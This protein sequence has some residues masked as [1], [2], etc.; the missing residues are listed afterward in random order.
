MKYNFKDRFKNYALIQRI[1][2]FI[3]T[4]LVVFLFFPNE[5]MIRYE[6][7]LNQPWK[8]DKLFAPFDFGIHKS[9]EEITQA[10]EEITSNQAPVFS[11]DQA[12]N[13]QML[14]RIDD[15]WELSVDS[16]YACDSI[17]KSSTEL[18]GEWLSTG[19]IQRGEQTRNL[20][21]FDPIFID[22]GG[23]L[24]S[25]SYGD[26]LNINMVF[27][28]MA[29]MVEIEA[30]SHCAPIVMRII[31]ENLVSNAAY[32]DSL[33]E[34]L[35]E[36]GYADIIEIEGK[37]NKGQSIIDRGEIVNNERY[38]VLASL[39]KEFAERTMSVTGFQWSLIGQMA[40]VTI[41]LGLLA[42]FIY[43]NQTR[44]FND[45]R[46]IT[47]SLS[48]VTLGFA[49][50]AIAYSS[51]AVSMY[52]IPIGI[53]PLLLRMF[54]DFRV[55]IFSFLI[56]ILMVALFSSNPLEYIL[57]QMSAISFATLYQSSSVKRSRM[58]GTAM[59]VFLGYS[60]IYMA[61]SVA[62][63]GSMN[64]IITANF[65]WF[66][67]NGLLC[68]MVFPLIY[69]VE[70]V[71]GYTSETTLLELSDS[72]Q[73]LLKE[74]AVKAPGTFQH[75]MQVAN[76]A[77]KISS[78]IGGNS[79][80]LRT[81]AM[82][83]DIGK[84]N[85]PQFFI[86]NQLPDNNPHDDLEPQESAQIII[87]HVRQGIEKALQ[88]NIPIDIIQFIQTHHGT[89]KARYFYKRALD[90]NPDADEATFTYPGPRPSTKEQAI[91]MMADSVEAASRSLKKYD[92]E[93]LERLV[94]MIID[95]QKD[96]GQFTEAPITFKDITIAKSVLKTALKG[97][98]HQRISYD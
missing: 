12:F 34:L 62:Q 50:S 27:D 76:L 18:I 51:N 37:V 69:V 52:I 26:A 36:N 94:D 84:M 72:N 48:L 66:A 67:I 39:E 47:L 56:L 29:G 43:M 21:R 93:S 78:K 31:T 86:E 81:A 24:T 96:D 16:N 53:A 38:K 4:L 2:A 42:L 98:F 33:T 6:Y 11:I 65:G 60:V 71:F 44:L 25:I 20:S 92:H 73:P 49:M 88:F 13:E 10:K 3:L 59:L 5:G 63:N 97:I 57:V 68:M 90:A 23:N 91:L 70:K 85:E 19:I 54:F 55:S 61:I 1:V 9:A 87:G 7:Q 17:R 79:V 95:G 89:S 32:N 46:P 15:A 58:L 82:Y 30:D 45:P 80:L 8:H 75:S 35:I 77:E 22:R 28:Y 83:H 74:L 64:G 40:I 41:L 14:S